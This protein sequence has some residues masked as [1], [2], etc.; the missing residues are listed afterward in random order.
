MKLFLACFTCLLI[1]AA[2]MPAQSEK[3]APPREESLSPEQFNQAHQSLYQPD[4][5]RRAGALTE[6]LLGGRDAA[7]DAPGGAVERRN[8]IDEF[9]FSKM[10]QDGIPHAPLASD[11]EFLRRAAL[12]L[13]GRI[14]T[15]DEVRAFRA[16]RDAEKRGKLIDRLLAS[17]AW[18]D[19]WSYFFLDLFRANG[20]MGRGQY[21]FHY[22]LKENLRSDRPYDQAV[23]QMITAS[24]KSNWVSAASN[25]IAREHVQGA[26]EPIDGDDLSMVQQ[27]DTHDELSI[28]YA[29]AFLGINLSCISCHDG[30]G[31]LEKVNVW[32]S[33]KT[34]EQFFRNASFLGR[35]RY[36]MYWENGRTLSNEFLIDDLAAGYDTKG[37]S[38]L[39]VARMGGSNEP[40]FLLNGDGPRPGEAPR[41]AL[42]RLL[43]ADP[44][45]ARATV[46]MFWARLMGVGIVEPFDEFDLA[47]QD[48]GHLPQG[49]P[50]QPS[51]PE[52]LDALAHDFA[53]NGYS[54][55]RLMATITKSSAYQLSAAFPGEWK[56][57]YTTYFARKYARRLS[58]EE[59]HDSIVLATERPAAFQ[60]KGR[61][62]GMAMRLTNPPARCSG[63]DCAD[64]DT[65]HFMRIFGQSDRQTHAKP[66][67]ASIQHSLVLMQSP[68]VNDRVRAEK[69]GRVQRLL[70]SYP[71]DNGRVVDEMFL[72][73]L[74][75]APSQG[76]RG[77]ALAAME[78]DRVAG[79][80]NLQWALI[81]STEFFFNY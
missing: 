2:G 15:P 54:L 81:N 51:H 80:E 48:P 40:A 35:T 57:A 78:K 18:V 49:W 22:W 44:Q 30:Q 39:R 74:A 24:A 26:A 16:D 38:M 56:D 28:I 25:V 64:A 13:T 72:A 45:F 50:L 12:D 19:K 47:R 77:V 5:S 58:A 37:A 1:A 14:P 75:R 41:D 62:Y 46:N 32:L 7:V 8:Y 23:R 61:R 73:S 66:T 60:Q 79:A 6:R 9:I 70:A 29:K 3:P 52:L 69:D 17:E 21:L 33:R 76:E 34:R 27:L 43:T 55:K 68:V 67:G 4:K 20:K 36:L 11:G 65:R 63:K 42:A 53:E 10:E 31:H 59:L 71:D